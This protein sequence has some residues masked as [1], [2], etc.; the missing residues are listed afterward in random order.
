MAGEREHCIEAGANDYVAKPV[1]SAELFAA[2][3]PWLSAP[4]TAAAP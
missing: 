3:T 1:D 4:V 2:L